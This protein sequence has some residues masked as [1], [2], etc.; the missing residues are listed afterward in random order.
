MVIHLE[1]INYEGTGQTISQLTVPT[2]FA[3]GDA[4]VYLLK[5]DTLSLVDAGV[6]TKAAWEA[7]KTQ[8]RQLGYAP[9]DIEQIILTHH[10]PDHIGLIEA[11]PRAERI[12][13]HQTRMHG[14][15]RMKPF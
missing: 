8:L 10:H 1:D 4:H 14:S 13:A 6:K 5:G 11:F 9:N 7:L 3:V 12:V 15:G 2:P